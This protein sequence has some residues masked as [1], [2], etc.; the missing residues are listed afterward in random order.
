MCPCQ[1]TSP[2]TCCQPDGMVPIYNR[3]EVKH[4]IPVLVCSVSLSAVET[5]FTRVLL[6]L[7]HC[8]TSI[9][10]IWHFAV[11]IFRELCLEPLTDN[12]CRD[13]LPTYACDVL[14]ETVSE[15]LE[16]MVQSLQL[17]YSQIAMLDSVE[18]TI[19]AKCLSSPRRSFY[20]VNLLCLSQSSFHSCP[21]AWCLP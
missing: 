16:L 2:S 15:K 6:F 8:I 13:C 21:H 3:G 17:M 19:L 18:R 14:C 10:A 9:T 4:A 5:A 20:F 7:M 1:S 12:S 11:C